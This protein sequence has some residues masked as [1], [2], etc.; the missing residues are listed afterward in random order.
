[1]VIDRERE[2]ERETYYRLVGAFLADGSEYRGRYG[3]SDER[4]RQFHRP[5]I[6]AILRG[7]APA[8]RA[9]KRERKRRAYANPALYYRPS[10]GYT[11]EFRQVA[12][13][14]IFSRSRHF[15][16]P[17]KALL[18]KSFLLFLQFEFPGFLLVSC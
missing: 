9:E 4:L 8:I 13:N 18:L 14:R 10:D 3:V 17:L 11:T 15:L 12:G 5:R 6:D 1:M 7:S 2:R 16:L